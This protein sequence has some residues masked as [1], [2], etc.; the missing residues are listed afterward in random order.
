MAKTFLKVER[1]RGHDTIAPPKYA[2][3]LCICPRAAH[4]APPS[5]YALEHL[6][7]TWAFAPQKDLVT[8]LH[9]SVE[10]RWPATPKRA[11]SAP[12]LSLIKI[13]WCMPY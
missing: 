8:P 4:P 13:V 2:L 12:S 9:L 5:G 11:R 6:E 10:D 1:G 7:K 3:M